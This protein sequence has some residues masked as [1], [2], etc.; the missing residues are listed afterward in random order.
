VNVAQ[1]IVAQLGGNAFAAITGSRNFL[2]SH[3][4]QGVTFMV[5]RGPRG[6]THVEIILEA[7]DTYRVRFS[8]LDSRTCTMT[9]LAEHGDVYVDQLLDVFEGETGLYATIGGRN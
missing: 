9:T 2:E 3:A 5:G 8:R 4:G 1:T 6:V 7:S